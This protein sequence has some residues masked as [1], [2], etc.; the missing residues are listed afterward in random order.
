MAGVI[1]LRRNK[2]C[3]FH[4]IHK[5]NPIL[6][7]MILYLNKQGTV[8]KILPNSATKIDNFKVQVL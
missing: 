7:I 8:S 1:K 3:V 5:N 2:E 4:N 6:K